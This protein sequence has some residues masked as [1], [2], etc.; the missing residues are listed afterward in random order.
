MF[1]NRDRE[2][3][4]LEQRY[5][6]TTA[7]MVI[8]YGRRR[9]GKTELLRTFCQGKSHLFFVGDLGTEESL[10]AEFTRQ[11]SEFAYGEPN[12]ISPFA[13]WE[14]AFS[15]LSRQANQERLIIVLDEF[16][17]LIGVNAALPSLLQKMWDTHLQA[18]QIM[19]ILCGSYIGMMEQQVLAY[20]SPLYGR[21]TGQWRLQPFTFWDAHKLLPKLT[22]EDMVRAFAILGGVPAYLRRFADDVT[23]PALARIT[24]SESLFCHSGGNSWWTYTFK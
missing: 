6:S 7:E 4:F 10:L 19:L 8:L 21:R 1:V 5:A 2:L 16:T 20:R 17:Y 22:A 15:F 9:V 14:A 12:A 13:T 18:T 23:L 24:R 3:R 11:I